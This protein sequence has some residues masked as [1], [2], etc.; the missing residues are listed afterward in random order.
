VRHGDSAPPPPRGRAGRGFLA[1]LWLLLTWLSA[2]RR[3]KPD[4]AAI[5]RQLYRTQTRGMALRMT[6]WLRDR[7]RPT[8]LRLRRDAD[9]PDSL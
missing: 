5:D 9:D 1:R 8:W 2:R 4:Q 7:L 6:E 3:L